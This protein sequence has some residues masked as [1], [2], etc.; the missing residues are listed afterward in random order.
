M[1]A[2]EIFERIHS[3]IGHQLETMKDVVRNKVRKVE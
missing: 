3:D 2:A 1:A